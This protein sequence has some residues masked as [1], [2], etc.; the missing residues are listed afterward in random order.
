MNT[1]TTG[2]GLIE[3]TSNTSLEKRPTQNLISSQAAKSNS[4]F[5]R[6]V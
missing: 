1:N 3:T 2:L 5:S 4:L 6:Q